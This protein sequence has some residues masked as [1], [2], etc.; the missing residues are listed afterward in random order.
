[1]NRNDEAMNPSG[2]FPQNS[3]FF[4]ASLA[5]PKNII[6]FAFTDVLESFALFFGNFCMDIYNVDSDEAMK[7]GDEA[8]NA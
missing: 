6:V 3:L 8:L 2:N 5:K 1:M 7:R 4:E